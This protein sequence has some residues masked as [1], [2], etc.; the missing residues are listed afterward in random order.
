LGK[1]DTL[2]RKVVANNIK[3]LRM[4]LNLNQEELAKMAGLERTNIS[5]LEKGAANPTIE[6]LEKLAKALGSTVNQL[7]DPKLEEDPGAIAD[8]LEAI[9]HEKGMSQKQ[10]AYKSGLGLDSIAGFFS[11][12]KKPSVESTKAL[13]RALNVN[14]IDILT[15]RPSSHPGPQIEESKSSDSKLDLIYKEVISGFAKN[16]TFMARIESL[17]SRIEGLLSRIESLVSNRK[18]KK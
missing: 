18:N 4:S 12:E 11:G 2:I 15:P 6:T 14:P 13:S 10:V 17:L 9:A 3:T 16:E 1:K 8:N 5:R 7:L